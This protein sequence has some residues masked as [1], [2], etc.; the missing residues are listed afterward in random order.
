ML[1]LA[2]ALAALPAGGAAAEGQPAARRAPDRAL[3]PAASH[4]TGLLVRAVADFNGDGVDDLLMQQRRGAA[5]SRHELELYLGPFAAQGPD[6]RQPDSRP[7]T[8]IGLDAATRPGGHT[9][10]LSATAP[11]FATDVDRD[12]LADIVAFMAV[13]LS[14]KGRTEWQRVAIHYGRADW[15]AAL[16]FG[17]ANRGDTVLQRQRAL[18][19]NES[20]TTAARL[21]VA[22][23]DVTGDGH[24]DL[25]IATSP[26]FSGNTR[27][28]NQLEVMPGPESW[29]RRTL[30]FEPAAKVGPLGPCGRLA[31]VA[32]VTGDGIEDVVARQCVG[33]MI[34]DV[35][36]VVPGGARWPGEVALT[37]HPSEGAE[38]TIPGPPR[39]GGRGYVASGTGDELGTFATGPLV[40]FEDLDDD[41]VRDVAFEFGGMT[42]VFAG[43]PDVDGRLSAGR[44]SGVLLNTSFGAATLTRAWRRA[45]LDG[46]GTRD[47]LVGTRPPQPAGLGGREPSRPGRALPSAINLYRGGRPGSLVLDAMA[48]A[49]DAVWR[50]PALLVWGIG[51]LNGDGLAD[52]L[53][54]PR[55]SHAALAYSIVFGPF[56]SGGPG[57]PPTP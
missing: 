32:D 2:L 55:P 42:H 7:V 28:Q 29:P 31:G 40:L 27:A 18:L 15:P 22:F 35:L 34:P 3:S 36:R 44:S 53:L 10:L 57:A 39:E 52:A 6:P 33:R 38:A 24:T 11:V 26:S 25:V 37:A 41:G 49:P 9:V 45:D 23:G 8:T 12:G 13:R 19:E 16:E 21:D 47:L 1:F 43:G 54:G 14:E 30:V 20:S 46:D 56:T 4:D 48:D 5:G 17:Q 50:D 51:D